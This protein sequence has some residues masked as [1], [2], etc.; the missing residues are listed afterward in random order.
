MKQT[1][2][3]SIKPLYTWRKRRCRNLIIKC[4]IGHSMM[5][6]IF[7][8]A[9]NELIQ[10]PNNLIKRTRT[11]TDELVAVQIVVNAVYEHFCLPRFNSWILSISHCSRRHPYISPYLYLTFY[12]SYC[13]TVTVV[14]IWRLSI[15]HPRKA[16]T[17]TYQ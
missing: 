9:G 6:L 15:Q 14:I 12:L 3:N 1:L 8:R 11:K 2:R 13:D 5:P 4:S 17:I 7:Y 16:C 10:L